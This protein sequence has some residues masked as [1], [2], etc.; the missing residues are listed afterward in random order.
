M[1]NSECKCNMSNRTGNDSKPLVAMDAGAQT[2]DAY[3]EREKILDQ[4]D[5]TLKEAEKEMEEKK[6]KKKANNFQGEDGKHCDY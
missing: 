4:R 3:V 6:N 5:K 1:G 2:D